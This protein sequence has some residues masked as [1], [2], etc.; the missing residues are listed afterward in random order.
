[1]L[2]QEFSPSFCFELAQCTYGCMVVGEVGWLKQVSLAELLLAEVI[3]KL[4]EAVTLLDLLH[5]AEVVL[6]KIFDDGVE[7]TL[8]LTLTHFLVC[9]GHPGKGPTMLSGHLAW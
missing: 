5:E 6:A 7:T 9:R 2:G 1:M 4:T 3:L 8:P